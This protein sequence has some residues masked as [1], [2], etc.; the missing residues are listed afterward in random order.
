MRSRKENI[1][2]IKASH[3]TSNDIILN[4]LSD[5]QIN[6]LA[7]QAVEEIDYEISERNFELFA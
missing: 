1:Q 3:P 6:S 7:N 5:D 2:F 4:V